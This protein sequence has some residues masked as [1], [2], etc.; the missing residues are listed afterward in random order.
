[1]KSLAEQPRDSCEL[2]QIQEAQLQVT[3]C[4]MLASDSA[5]D[6]MVPLSDNLTGANLA[7][8]YQ[9]SEELWCWSIGKTGSILA[10]YGQ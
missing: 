3:P 10:R 6:S 8:R 7:C 5:D 2:R 1:M 9:P 4:C